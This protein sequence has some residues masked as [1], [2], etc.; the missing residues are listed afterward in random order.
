MQARLSFFILFF[1][2]LLLSA[3]PAFSAGGSAPSGEGVSPR[4]EAAID[5]AAGY[6]SKC[7]LKASAKYA[8]KGN[9]DR[10]LAQ[11]AKC[12]DKFDDQVA[13]AQDRF[14]EDQCTLYTSEIADRTVSYTAGV[15]SEASGQSAP[16]YLFVQTSESAVLTDSTLT[17]TRVSLQTGWFT[18][19]PYREA[20]QV[21]TFAFLGIWVE[22]ADSFVDDPPNADLTCEVD[23]EVVNYFLELTGFSVAGNDLIYTVQG[24]GDSDLPAELTCD[25]DA[26]LFIDNAEED[27][28]AANQDFYFGCILKC[29][30]T[31]GEASPECKAA[32]TP[33]PS[34][35]SKCV[36]NYAEGGW[37]CPWNTTCADWRE[38]E[39]V[40][41]ECQ[42]D[43]SLPACTFR[44]DLD[45][46]PL[47][48]GADACSS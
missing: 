17:L 45:C 10:L 32:F 22:G 33:Y 23:R 31:T 20:G 16:E 36:P 15:A 2:A 7:L 40:A 6:Y 47:G 18:D 21:L 42:A 13:R 1:S 37:D 25:G 48:G 29:L 28:V 30:K 9:E 3:S 24:I 26:H 35:I 27:V 41:E 38:T 34:E 46:T 11:Q 14:G 12:D 43:P 5:K 8:K 44:S 19:R 39:R 4:C